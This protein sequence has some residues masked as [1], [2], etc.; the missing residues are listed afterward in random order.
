VH[1]LVDISFSPDL[2]VNSIITVTPIKNLSI[3]LLSKYVSSQYLDNTGSSDRMI[4]SY[5]VHNFRINY[6]IYPKFM[7]EID[8]TLL[9]NNITSLKYVSNGYTYYFLQQSSSGTNT[10]VNSNSFF[11]QALI[12]VLGGVNLKF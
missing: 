5:F 3:S 10:E 11:P 7:K 8:L 2:I 12:S 9:V 6:A 4:P 1:S